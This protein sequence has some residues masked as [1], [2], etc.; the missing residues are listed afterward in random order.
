MQVREKVLVKT[1]EVLQLFT[2]AAVLY[3]CAVKVHPGCTTLLA[4]CRYPTSKSISLLVAF[5]FPS[6]VDSCLL[7]RV[8]LSCGSLASMR[9]VSISIPKKV[10]ERAGPSNFSSASGMLR[11]WQVCWMAAKLS[12][13]VVESAQPMIRNL[14]RQCKTGDTPCWSRIQAT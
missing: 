11:F 1:G 14:S 7:M 2:L 12:W 10:R 5:F 9:I 6:Q 3:I 13:H 8:N 4:C